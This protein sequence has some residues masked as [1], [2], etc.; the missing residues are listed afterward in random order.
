MPTLCDSCPERAISVDTAY[1]VRFQ[2]HVIGPTVVVV[3]LVLVSADLITV[4]VDFIL[5]STTSSCWGQRLKF[6]SRQGTLLC[7]S[8][9]SFFLA[10]PLWHCPYDNS[11]IE[12]VLRFPLLI[13]FS[14]LPGVSTTIRGPQLRTASL[15]LIS[16]TEELEWEPPDNLLDLLDQ[17]C[18]SQD[19][20]L[21]Q[22]TVL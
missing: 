15:M 19:Q 4:V 2:V 8:F 22:R 17:M 12:L 7:S 11:L 9:N 1:Q 16:I 13:V 20:G 10:Y 21:A 14:T 18:R 6:K 3:D 5:T